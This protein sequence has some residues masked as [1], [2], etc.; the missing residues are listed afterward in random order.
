VSVFLID[1]EGP[2]HEAVVQASLTKLEILKSQIKNS[3]RL[4]DIAEEE[5]QGGIRNLRDNLFLSQQ[6]HVADLIWVLGELKGVL[7]SWGDTEYLTTM[8]KDRVQQFTKALEQKIK[9][10]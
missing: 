8:T 9:E 10:N 1:V 3:E 4:V 2:N 6:S 5:I 7:A